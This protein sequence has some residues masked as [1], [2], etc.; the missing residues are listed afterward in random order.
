MPRDCKN[1]GCS[2]DRKQKGKSC[3]CKK[4]ESTSSDLTY[5]CDD[6]RQRQRSS[7]C[8]SSSSSSST[9]SSTSS[10]STAQ[11]CRGCQDRCSNCVSCISC[12]CRDC[13]DYSRSSVLGSLG[14]SSEYCPDLD[15]LALD[16]KK[17]CC[18]DKKSKKHGG[19]KTKGKKFCVTFGSSTGSTTE[20]YNSGTE[21]IWVNSKNQPILH[22]YR[23]NTYFFCVEQGMTGSTRQYSLI[24]T[25]SPSGGPGS[26]LIPG[27]F[28]P[29]SSGCA[30]FKVD[31]K[32]PRYFYYQT[33]TQ[34]FM[35]SL[36]IVHDS[37]Y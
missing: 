22:L 34:T 19:Q 26:N 33:T 29:I 25:D 16:K 4:E 7:S 15:A 11:G 37:Q 6:R 17:K 35:G 32:T 20:S 5:L 8:S 9:C 28:A 21:S 10:S 3:G 2:S 12:G 30:S 36:C 23:G 1:Q 18:G 13:S 24:L 14:S 31:S 27:A